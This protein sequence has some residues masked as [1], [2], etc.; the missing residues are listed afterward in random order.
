MAFRFLTWAGGRT[1]VLFTEMERLGGKQVG[2]G[3]Y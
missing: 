2:D 1:I 3:G